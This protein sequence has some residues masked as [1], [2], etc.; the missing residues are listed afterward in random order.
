MVYIMRRT[1]LYLDEDLWKALHARARRERTTV[2]ELVRQAARDRFLRN[3]EE[4]RADMMAAVGIWKD[5]T[6]LPDTETYVRELRR[7]TRFKRLGIE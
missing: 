5:R 2:S 3:S 4:R 6:D 7:G 1:Q